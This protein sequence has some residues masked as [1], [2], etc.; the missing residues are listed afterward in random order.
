MDEDA[1][2]LPRGDVHVHVRDG[3]IVAVAP[4]V[5]APAEVIDASGMIVMPGFI[6]THWHMG[7][8]IAALE[9][10][11]HLNN[12]AQCLLF[13]VSQF[14]RDAAE[15][16]LR[17]AHRDV[18]AMKEAFHSRRDVLCDALESIDGLVVHR[19]AGPVSYSEVARGKTADFVNLSP[20]EI[21]RTG[22]AH[23][24]RAS[25][26]VCERSRFCR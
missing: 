18:R 13:G 25:S 10:A 21:E 7:W 11:S 5:S 22:P 14:T 23:W 9:L 20:E 6:D 24:I 12:L 19:P 15:L 16:A 1:G 17:E 2:E 3:E 26:K 4:S 8:T